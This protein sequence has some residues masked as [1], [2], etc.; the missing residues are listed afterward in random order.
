MCPRSLSASA[1]GT[2]EDIEGA[3]IP[4]SPGGSAEGKEWLSAP[5]GICEQ[6][7]ILGL[8]RGSFIA[9]TGHLASSILYLKI[10]KY[11]Y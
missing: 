8:S 10:F 11:F 6:E 4:E 7:V 2:R 5:T 3:W 9:T 1:A